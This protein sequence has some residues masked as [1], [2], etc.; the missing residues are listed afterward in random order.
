MLLTDLNH[1]LAGKDLTFDITIREI[2]E[3]PDSGKEGKDDDDSCSC[4]GDCGCNHDHKGHEGR[5]DD[6]CDGD[7]CK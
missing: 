6:C 4:G 5:D 2:K 1:P 3:T 7:C